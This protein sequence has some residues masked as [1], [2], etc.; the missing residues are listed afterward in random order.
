LPSWE[1]L[2]PRSRRLPQPQGT[3]APDAIAPTRDV[4]T[5]QE[6]FG[7]GSGTSEDA[8][9]NQKYDYFRFYETLVPGAGSTHLE[10]K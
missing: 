3:P 9:A 4:W 2:R 7:L 6:T 10:S 1:L 5:S 8:A